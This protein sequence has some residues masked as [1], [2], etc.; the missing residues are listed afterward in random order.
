MLSNSL[1]STNSTMCCLMIPCNLLCKD[2]SG[3]LVA[4]CTCPLATACK[5]GLLLVYRL[6]HF[7]C[8][9]S[10]FVARLGTLRADCDFKDTFGCQA[11]YQKVGLWQCKPDLHVLSSQ[12]ATASSL[13]SV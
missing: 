12:A 5:A 3:L 9:K 10:R 7:S 13:G 11:F 1:N 6:V 2:D 4:H 8:T